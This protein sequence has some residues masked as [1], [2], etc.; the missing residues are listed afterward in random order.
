MLGLLLTPPNG[1][2]NG[3]AGRAEGE[4]AGGIGSHS[5]GVAGAVTIPTGGGA[6]PA[7]PGEFAK[8][9]AAVQ[10]GGPIETPGG[11]VVDGAVAAAAAIEVVADP[12]LPLSAAAVGLFDEPLVAGGVPLPAAAVATPVET[13][14]L[15]PAVI[16]PSE[17][18]GGETPAVE[19][20]AS[21]VLQT[22]F[23]PPVAL[24]FEDGSL[25]RRP[26]PVDRPVEAEGVDAEPVAERPI[27][28]ADGVPVSR[29]DP[30]VDGFS[31]VRPAEL[32]W[33][34]REE[35]DVVLP[36]DVGPRGPVVPEAVDA[37]IPVGVR[38]AAEPT[39]FAP[40]LEQSTPGKST[41]ERKLDEDSFQRPFV[42]VDTFEA[43]ATGGPKVASE[44]AAIA[45]SPEAVAVS[46]PPE[47]T[48]REDGPVSPGR[49][50]PEAP[51]GRP[52]EAGPAPAAPSI[53]PEDGR[54]EP[55]ASPAE[56][57]V[58]LAASHTSQAAPDRRPAP[59]RSRDAASQDRF[60]LP[61]STEE[62]TPAIVS[63]EEP[64]QETPA[65]DDDRLVETAVPVSQTFAVPP[66]V[67]TTPDWQPPT[68]PDGPTPGLSQPVGSAAATAAGGPEVSPPPAAGPQPPVDAT[69][70]QPASPPTAESA[71]PVATTPVPVAR[72]TVED[73]P[74]AARPAEAVT[75]EPP[76]VEPS[77]N[78]VPPTADRPVTA[79]VSPN[80]EPQTATLTRAAA[81]IADTVRESL[82]TGVRPI[83]V[84]LDP[85]E[86]GGVAVEAHRVEGKLTVRLTFESPEAA[87]LAG[88]GLPALREMLAARG[89]DGRDV[90]IQI[91]LDRTLSDK[92]VDRSEPTADR[93]DGDAGRSDHRRDETHGGRDGCRRS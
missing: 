52:L 71:G 79:E 82:E 37:P 27:V 16:V 72:P 45:R 56:T 50:R 32:P 87:K 39:P 36:A 53:R 69:L 67:T 33:P 18:V 57:G 81:T 88:D 65:R 80:R 20:P 25:A 9:L 51:A 92:T 41:T 30:A 43:A 23:S 7:V 68:V 1:S 47:L 70:L 48:G 55:P 62:R 22:L 91:T 78:D 26:L 13:A 58:R 21:D 14:G 12:G 6:V 93:R 19:E 86:L 85:P 89:I 84:R 3:G 59:S 29:F 28:P 38:Q 31:D 15:L 10:T 49:P 77:A 54:T 61:P 42:P 17:A 76:A 63:A 46:L 73:V 83:R 24:D 11:D 2:P 34:T 40:A 5:A 64:S 44:D 4:T 75:S 74:I 35:A 90:D 8:L 60:A 66:P